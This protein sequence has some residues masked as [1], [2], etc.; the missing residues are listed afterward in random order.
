MPSFPLHS[1]L[2]IFIQSFTGLCILV[3]TFGFCYEAWFS[4]I[5]TLIYDLFSVAKAP[6]VSGLFYFCC[7][8]A[9]LILPAFQTLI[10]GGYATDGSIMFEPKID[11][12]TMQTSTFRETNYSSTAPPPYATTFTNLLNETN[13]LSR[14]LE[15]GRSF[16]NQMVMVML[17]ASLLLAIVTQCAMYFFVVRKKSTRSQEKDEVR[18]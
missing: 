3:V 16:G 15:T 11:N 9:T 5:W 14:A 8:I 13:S 12:S 18:S 2:L 17:C 7:G 4:I 1:V 6:D 10:L